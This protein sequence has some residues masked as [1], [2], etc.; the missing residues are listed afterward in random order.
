RSIIVV[1]DIQLEALQDPDQEVDISTSTTPNVQT[2]RKICEAAKSQGVQ[3]LIIAYDAFWLAYR[4]DLPAD[5]PRELYPDSD[6]YIECV[7]N[8]SR[9]VAS[10]GMGLE[11]SLLTPLEIGKEFTQAT[12]ETGRWVQYREGYR[13]S[14]T[15]QFS[16][17]LWEHK[18]WRNNKGTILIDRG[19]IR[20]FAFKE[21]NKFAQQPFY[22]INEDEIVELEG[23]FNVMTPEDPGQASRIRTVVSGEGNRAKNGASLD[24]YNRVMVVV[25][26]NTPEMDYFSPQARPFLEKLIDKYHQAGV[27][28]NAFYSD[29]IHIQQDTSYFSHH[30]A[31]QF[32]FRYLSDNYIKA[33]A[34]KYG[35]KYLDFEK[36]LVYFLYG[37][38]EFL[39][40]LDA[41]EP[42]QHFFSPDD[43][44]I[45]ETWLF[46][47]HYYDFLDK[48]VIDLFAGVKHY[49]EELYGKKLLARAHATWAQSPTIDRWNNRS[50]AEKYEY[51]PNFVW[52]NTVQQAAA[53]CDDYFRWNDFL[54]GGGNDH[55]EGG[56][57]D[58]D[59]YGQAIA[60]STGATNDIPNAY[61]GAWGFP[62]AVRERH[63]AINNAFGTQGMVQFKAIEEVVHRDIEVLM[64][65]PISLVAC[66]ERFGSWMVQYGYANYLT[67]EKLL[68]YGVIQDDGTVDVRGKRYNTIC[69][70]FEPFPPLA[71]FDFLE[72]FIAKG[73]KVVWSGPPSQ[74]SLEGNFVFDRWKKLFGITDVQ[75]NLTGLAVPGQRI[76]FA[77]TFAGME[78][79]TVLTDFMIDHIYPFTATDGVETV[80]TCSGQLVGAKNGNAIYL[81]FRPRDDQAAS[82]GYESKTWYDALLRIGSYPSSGKN[83]EI[84]DNPTVISRTTPYLATR[85][86]NGTVVLVTH[87]SRHKES[88]SGGFHRDAEQDKKYI[89]QNPL[90]SD[91][92]KFENFAVAGHRI[93]YTGNLMVAFRMNEA[94]QLIAFFGQNCADVTVDGRTFTFADK[95]M[96][97]I[98]WAPVSQERRVEG[99]A[100]LE[101]WTS[102][103]AKVRIPVAEPVTSP[104]LFVKGII[105]VCGE[106]VPCTFTDGY[107]EFDAPAKGLSY[108]LIG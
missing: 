32:T 47:R 1:S 4:K 5:K 49:A 34:A 46:R 8:I 73:G 84:N 93:D 77:G 15:G 87:Y 14:S 94:G 26:Y 62:A 44:G 71:L 51:T 81:G 28:L 53:A 52:S 16:V 89:E 12:G 102:N 30:D 48:S 64:L 66:E 36:Y 21:G 74:I 13:E 50:Q 63:T 27:A 101:I 61:A 22:A 6:K 90:P 9:F 82:L 107:L 80:A 24:G 58:R 39:D 40:S 35:E 104:R 38:H 29:E 65:Y 76:E 31:G 45:Q 3:T 78:N 19:D 37:Q 85:F 7:A 100:I 97:S 105:G 23:P 67:A 108:Y 75:L 10:Y 60:C 2:L 88:W 56:W 79:Q 33:F 54:T 69:A 95:K 55:A 106:E 96:R 91:E 86:P 43:K 57:S 70:L 59:Y 99:G 25:Y 98:A 42:S 20:V 68:Q 72:N 18:R 83:G 92:L 41:R 11:L 103:E 17:S